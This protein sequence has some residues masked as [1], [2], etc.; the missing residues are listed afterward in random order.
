MGND[1]FKFKEFTVNQKDSV[2][3]VNT[4]GV[5]LGAWMSLALSDK[6]LLDVGTGTG[7]IA[8]MAAQRL[9]KIKSAA[10]QNS[11][12]LIY[13]ID[14]DASSCAE[15]KIN[16]ENSK[17][18]DNI[19]AEEIDF[20]KFSVRYNNS[21]VE[22]LLKGIIGQGIT[23]K[24][25]LKFDLIFS[26]PPYF[27]D[28]LKSP[29]AEK[30]SAKHNDNLSQSDLIKG[31]CAS[32]KIGGKFAL[33]LP[34]DEAENF[35][36]KIKFLEEH[37]SKREQVPFLQLTRR[38]N[39]IYEKG[40]PPRRAL[41][42]FAYSAERMPGNICDLTIQDKSIFTKEYKELTKEFYINF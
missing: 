32:L 35:I 40:T 17:W 31:V 39:V 16:F 38:C 12:F 14:C 20:Q 23:I 33:I 42:E 34:I 29:S 22:S 30:S 25:A 27:T 10:G 6:R 18:R 8:L 21:E 13:G 41:M 7:V 11:N 37:L 9:Q 2:M 19:I 28:S 36:R 26:N 4:D 5:L 15:A 24:D 3:R 1:Y